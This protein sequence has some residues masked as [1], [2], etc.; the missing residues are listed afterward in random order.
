MAILEF[1]LEYVNHHK[2]NKL[3]PHLLLLFREKA[4]AMAT[5]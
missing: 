4:F 2:S 1:K 5:N 3:L